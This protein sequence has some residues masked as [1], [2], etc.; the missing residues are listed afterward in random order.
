MQNEK[1]RAT[2]A[3]GGEKVGRDEGISW[4]QLPLVALFAAVAAALANTLVY[5]AASGLG[6]ISQ[7]VL[8][9]SPMG[10]SPLTVGL[11]VITSVIGV[12]GAAI[13][14]AL[15]GLFIRRPVRMFRIAATVV[16][17]LSFAMPA[18]VPG[19]P[20]TMRLSLGVMHIVAWAVS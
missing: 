19:V 13:V 10:M 16:L 4:K 18:T 9:P 2:E 17:V 11:V 5:F 3:T 20:V 14:F 1:T 6:T 12:I 15:I 8:L 7:S